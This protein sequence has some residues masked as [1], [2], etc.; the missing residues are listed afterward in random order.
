VEKFMAHAWHPWTRLH[1]HTPDE[2]L[3]A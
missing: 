1:R 3:L 2:E